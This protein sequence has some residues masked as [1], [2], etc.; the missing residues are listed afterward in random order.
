MLRKLLI[1]MMA[2][3]LTAMSAGPHDLF[4]KLDSYFLSPKLQSH[5]AC[6]EW[7]LPKQ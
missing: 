2:I 1:A 6:A 5:R 7:D 3:A 4:L